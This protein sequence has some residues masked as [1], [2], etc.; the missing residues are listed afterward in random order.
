[1]ALTQLCD[2]VASERDV[3]REPC[4]A[5]IR[6][7]VG[8]EGILLTD[9]CPRVTELTG[10][11]GN[12]SIAVDSNA[13]AVRLKYVFVRFMRASLQGEDV[14]PVCGMTCNGPTKSS[15]ELTQ[16]TGD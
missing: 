16:G 6:E 14:C 15:L 7:A 9:I 5:A 13:A 4:I 12:L 11:Q 1:V 3:V 10:Q 2:I 8:N